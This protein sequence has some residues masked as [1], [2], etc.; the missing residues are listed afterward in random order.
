L[1]IPQPSKLQTIVATAR[2][3]RASISWPTRLGYPTWGDPL[4]GDPLWGD[5][6]WGH[7]IWGHPIWGHPI[8]GHPIWGHPCPRKAE[9]T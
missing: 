8:W 5:P 6:L 2:T 7:P 3:G 4:W 9:P 1:P